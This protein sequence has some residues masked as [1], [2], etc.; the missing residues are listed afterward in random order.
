MGSQ[1]KLCPNSIIVY[2]P[3]EFFS[4]KGVSDSGRGFSFV[5]SS[6][7][8]Q[9]FAPSHPHPSPSLSMHGPGAGLLFDSILQIEVI[10]SRPAVLSESPEQAT[11]KLLNERLLL[12]PSPDEAVGVF[13]LAQWFVSSLVTFSKGK[14][15]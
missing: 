9:D 8:W 14:Y 11:D 3:S 10:K 5:P 6:A 13:L 15:L 12:R 2:L 4:H 1:P 7:T